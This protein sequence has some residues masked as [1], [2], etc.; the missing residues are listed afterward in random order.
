MNGPGD[1]MQKIEKDEEEKSFWVQISIIIGLIA[2]VTV[3]RYLFNLIGATQMFHA[4]K[5]WIQDTAG[6]VAILGIFVVLPIL[7]GLGAIYLL[8]AFIKWCWRHS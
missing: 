8:V 6:T 2:V 4:A 7:L 5:T 3:L 1:T